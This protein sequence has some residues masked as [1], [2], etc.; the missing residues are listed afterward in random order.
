MSPMT[1]PPNTDKD[2]VTPEATEETPKDRGR[3]GLL[4]SFMPR[5]LK[6]KKD[7]VAPGATE[8]TLE[9]GEEEGLLMSTRLEPARPAEEVEPPAVAEQEQ[10]QAETDDLLESAQDE[11]A[12]DSPAQAPQD[13]AASPDP[14]EASAE[15]ETPATAEPA[16]QESTPGEETSDEADDDPLAAFRSVGEESGASDLTKE[17]EDIPIE[18]LLASAREVRSMLPPALAAAEGGAG[19]D[20]EG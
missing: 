18:E 9:Q 8:E 16:E 3:K 10:G 1:P 4:A 7:E 14:L 5:F 15:Q 12:V 13:A 17:I 19:E 2:E 6:S 11:T 20:G